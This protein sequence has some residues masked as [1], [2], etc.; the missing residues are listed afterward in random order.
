MCDRRQEAGG[1]Y[2][3]F[4]PFLFFLRN[5]VNPG[6]KH[7]SHLIDSVHGCYFYYVL[8]RFSLLS[9]VRWALKTTFLIV[10]LNFFIESGAM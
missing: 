7:A 6:E 4:F 10:A 3:Y 2:I 9:S 8:W 5:G 1:V